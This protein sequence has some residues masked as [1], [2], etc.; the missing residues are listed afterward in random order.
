MSELDN[1]L[2][3]SFVVDGSHVWRQIIAEKT[4]DPIL[5]K[6]KQIEFAI[7]H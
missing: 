5:L 4:A 7:Q 6:L 1:R 3:Q 2:N